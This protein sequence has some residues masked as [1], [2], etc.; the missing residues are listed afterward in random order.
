MKSFKDYLN[1]ALDRV[2]LDAEKDDTPDAGGYDIDAEVR[3]MVFVT[4]NALGMT[5]KQLAER[6]GVSQANISRIENGSYHPS[7]SVLKR[8]AD[9][10]GK[11]LVISFEELEEGE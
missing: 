1:Q 7:L 2:E 4:R 9:G 8:I 3:T 5:Q 10:F 6:S 11:R